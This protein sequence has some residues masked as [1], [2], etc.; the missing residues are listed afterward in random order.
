MLGVSAGDSEPSAAPCRP[1]IFRTPERRPADQHASESSE[2][3]NSRN[4]TSPLSEDSRQKDEEEQ[5][6]K[7][8]FTFPETSLRAQQHRDYP[9]GKKPPL[10]Y[11]ALIA[12]ALENAP[13]GMMTLNE[14][15]DFIMNT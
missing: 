9:P 2:S 8:L 15:Y 12:M 5:K 1:P 14:I 4:E 11:I 3:D 7:D 10:S 6:K 13:N